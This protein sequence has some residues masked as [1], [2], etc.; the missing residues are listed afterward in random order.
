MDIAER[1]STAVTPNKYWVNQCHQ[2]FQ[3]I[4][5]NGSGKSVVVCSGKSVVVCILS[6]F[7]LEWSYLTPGSIV[8][9]KVTLSEVASLLSQNPTQLSTT[10][11]AQG[12]YTYNIINC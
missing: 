2:V 3:I 9:P 1:V 6:N 5:E 10:I 12:R 7:E 8:L 11:R 4:Q